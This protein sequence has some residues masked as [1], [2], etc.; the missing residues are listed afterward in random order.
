MKTTVELPDS[1]VAE[2]RALARARGSTL[3]ELVTAGL[4]AELDRRRADALTRR[5]VF[6]T[7]S[8]PG[9]AAGVDPRHLR[10]QAYDLPAGDP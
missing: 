5:F 10:E 3:R 7:A 4:R 8:G 9:L 2:A 6:P 1:L